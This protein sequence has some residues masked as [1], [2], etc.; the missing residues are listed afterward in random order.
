MIQD[1]RIRLQGANNVR[2][3]GGVPTMDGGTV[4]RGKLFRADALHRLTDDD[5]TVLA[6]Y[7]IATVLDFR[8]TGELDSTGPGRLVEIGAR[9]QHFPLMPED[10]VGP[11]MTTI[12]ASLGELYQGIARARERSERIAA[13]I[14]EL[15]HVENM[16]LIFHCAAGKDRT[17][18]T[19]A[20]IYSILGVDRKTIVADY[21]ITDEALQLL[22][23]GL[24]EEERS[25]AS[26]VSESFMRAE[27]VTIT[28]FLDTLD[29]E[30]GSPEQW[31]LQSGATQ[32]S[33]DRLRE[34]MLD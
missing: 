31:M 29:S 3:L 8:S 20:T 9:H 2:D 6:A 1:R 18:I 27:A 12:P 22:L 19:A 5:L 11:G 14:N 28:L 15:A 24:S 32:D 23:G 33:F 25:Q 13:A 30:F 4:R 26:Q 10:P 21:V 16:P 7:D 34:A 17:G